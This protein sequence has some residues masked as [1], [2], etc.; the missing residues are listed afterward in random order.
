MHING[1]SNHNM[2]KRSDKKDTAI[3][4]V[5]GTFGWFSARK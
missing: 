5:V 3:V 2:K 1:N 4:C